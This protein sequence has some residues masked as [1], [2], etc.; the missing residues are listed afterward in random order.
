MRIFW[1]KLLDLG[2]KFFEINFDSL[3]IKAEVDP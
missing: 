2:K 3:G 1:R